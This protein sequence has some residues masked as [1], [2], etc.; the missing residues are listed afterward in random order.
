MSSFNPPLYFFP[1]GLIG[2]IGDLLADQTQTDES[3]ASVIAAPVA[4]FL[5]A[6]VIDAG[7]GLENGELAALPDTKEAIVNNP[8][9]SVEVTAVWKLDF[10]FL[11]DRPG[12]QIEA[13]KVDL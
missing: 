11:G 3:V 7:E 4:N 5:V 6:F 1:F 10:Q 9:I 12:L 2:S 8:E 13:S